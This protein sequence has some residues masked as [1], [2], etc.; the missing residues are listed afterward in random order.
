MLVWNILLFDPLIPCSLLHSTSEGSEACTYKSHSLSH[1][2][3]KWPEQD[4]VASLSRG[5]HPSSG[6]LEP[7]KKEFQHAP[8]NP[9]CYLASWTP[10]ILARFEDNRVF[11][12]LFF[13]LS[14]KWMTNIS[15]IFSSALRVL[16]KFQPL[17]LCCL[18]SQTRKS[19]TQL[20]A[21]MCRTAW[22]ELTL[23]KSVYL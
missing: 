6:L 20:S 3:G 23:K 17:N 10:K 4:Q 12:F 14:L 8:L 11:C 22:L 7:I 9:V 5:S 18:R 15:R 16:I 19:R 2:P 21:A 13:Y 1:A